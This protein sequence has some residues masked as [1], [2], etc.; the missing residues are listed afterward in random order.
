MRVTNT[1]PVPNPARVPCPRGQARQAGLGNRIGCIPHPLTLFTPLC[2]GLHSYEQPA[3]FINI[4]TRA[5]SAPPCRCNTG[6]KERREWVCP[7]NWVLGA[8]PHFGVCGC[9]PPK[10]A[11]GTPHGSARRHGP[12]TEG[13]Q[14]D[15]SIKPRRDPAMATSEDRSF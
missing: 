4:L 5:H 11:S 9:A 2:H 6:G 10:N 1:P 13:E 8:P 14:E 7:E 3:P 12:R 15:L